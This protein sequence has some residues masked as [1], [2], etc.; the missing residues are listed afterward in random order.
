MK[1]ITKLT[2]FWGIC[3][4][5]PIVLAA[6]AEWPMLPLQYFILSDNQIYMWQVAGILLAFFSA[7]WSFSAFRLSYIRKLL[8]KA[9]AEQRVTLYCRFSGTQA[10]CVALSLGVNTFLYYCTFS[11][12]AILCILVGLAAAI[13]AWPTQNKLRK[14]VS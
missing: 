6:L 2:A 12:N 4:L 7:Y 1:T 10:V 8:R 9:T 11:L 14:E 13:L 5:F 3:L